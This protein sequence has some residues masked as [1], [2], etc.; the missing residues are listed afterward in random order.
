MINFENYDSEMLLARGKY[1]TIRKEHEQAKKELSQLV[2]KLTS[3]ASQI[4]RKMQ[5]DFDDVPAS[6]SDLLELAR[7][8]ITEMEQTAAR[9]TS[10]AQQKEDL[11]SIAWPSAEG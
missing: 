1:S 2:G 3:C 9:I 7:W 8:T 11:R 4:L 10:L 5:P 6:Q